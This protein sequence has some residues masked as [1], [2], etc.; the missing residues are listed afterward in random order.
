MAY[1]GSA[2][3]KTVFI[4]LWGF[5]LQIL[6]AQDTGV[7]SGKVTGPEGKP[8]EGVH[9][10]LAQTGFGA[11]SEID[12]FYEIKGIPEG[13]YLL[14]ISKI[15]YREQQI[16]VSIV[17]GETTTMDIALTLSTFH[18]DDVAVFGQKR[19]TIYATRINAPLEQTPISV[20]IVSKELI[21]QQQVISLEDALKNVSGV[22]KFGSYGL[23][24]NINIRG[25]DIGL[26]GGPENYRVNGI[27][28]RTPYSDYV[29]EVQVLKGPASI[30]YGDVEPGGI[31]NYVTK[32][33][34][35]YEH[36]SFEVK[37]GEYGLL[38]PSI[39]LGGRLNE[40]LSYRLNTVYETSDSF[41]NA[42]MNKQ[43]MIAPSLRWD[44]NEKTVLD[45]DALFMNNKTTLD[46]GTPV[47]LPLARAKQLDN[48][49]F[50]GYPDGTSEG[51]NTTL[52][53]TFTHFFS[54]NW[55]L[56][57]VAAYSNQPRL[58]HDV[59]PVYN[60]ENDNVDFSFGDYRERSETT[61][62]S[63]FLDITGNL[64]TGAVR[65]RLL[66]GF[67]ISHITRPVSSNSTFPISQTTS[68]NNPVWEDTA[69]STAPVLDDDIQ[70]FTTRLGLNFQDLVALFDD[71]L[72][73]LLGG[74]FSQFTTGRKFR[75]DAT[76]PDDYSDEKESRFTPRVGF[77]YE[78]V[79]GITAYGSYAESFNSV[80]SQ[81]DRGL[82]DPDPLLG[83][84]IEFGTRLSLLKDRF[85]VTLS[86]FD[87]NREN[88]LQFDIIDPNGSVSDPNNF[89]ANQSG[90]H[91]SRGVE[92][93]IN[94][95]IKDNWQVYAA[96]SYFK[97]E[98]IS[99]TIQSGT[100]EPI[101]FTGKELPNNPNAKLSLWTH[102]K[103]Q[104]GIPGLFLGGGVFYQGDM[105]GDRLNTDENIIEAFT[106]VDISLGYQYKN[107]TLQV[108]IN[109]VGNVNTFQRSIFDSFVPQFPRRV[110]T[111]IAYTL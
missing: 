8:Q 60:E 20:N 79:D 49:N 70:P 78:I 51:N 89:R 72:N 4:V 41:R 63:N 111:S 26:A 16:P 6:T 54:D 85:G 100:S 94:G 90:E 58:L 64:Q 96:Y 48:T 68:L 99:E 92:L 74:R 21:E 30:L 40:N 19:A 82:D 83:K 46:W 107:L 28:L 109:N 34:L 95:K 29:E 37:I 22:S 31:V 47:F 98:V 24:D 35:G 33:P 43:F 10:F 84:Q 1:Y 38:R 45:L 91:N 76:T 36:A 2:P 5:T 87:L 102:Y 108:N 39:D 44:I 56:R 66:A 55:K 23:S 9:L 75:G 18:L 77:T 27:M 14:S 11:S 69:L 73:L 106:G 17:A 104:R 59:Y 25:F 88:V 86:Y 93:D 80:M 13:N 110:I 97:T 105:F 101:D 3:L 65:H 12:G 32:K 53:A 71:K 52:S 103:L 67:D 61:T 57:N 62:Y 42:V 50:Y 7:I 15:G 81:P